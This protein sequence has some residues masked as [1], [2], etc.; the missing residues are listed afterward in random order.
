MDISPVMAVEIEAII[1][2]LRQALGAQ[3]VDNPYGWYNSRI[4]LIRQ[5]AYLHQPLEG[6]HVFT[7]LHIESFIQTL[8]EQPDRDMAYRVWV[9]SAVVALLQREREKMAEATKW[10]YDEM[11]D[12]INRWQPA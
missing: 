12:I 1:D 10:A 8:R 4:A 6:D 5:A 2:D 3:E 7:P 9:R 11:I